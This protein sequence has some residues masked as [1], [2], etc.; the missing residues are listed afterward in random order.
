[1]TPAAARGQQRFNKGSTRANDLALLALRIARTARPN[2]PPL[3]PPL[4]LPMYRHSSCA[5]GAVRGTTWRYVSP[6]SPSLN[7]S[8][9]SSPPLPFPPH[10]QTLYLC[11]SGSEAN[12]LALRIA[13]TARPG[14]THVAVMAGAYHGHLQ[15]LIEMSPYKFW[16]TGG[17]GRPVHVH[18]LP[19]PDAYR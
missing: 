18:V 9:L 4:C 8:F 16:G 15:A 7:L 2:F 6:V 1:M 12:D 5:T 19:C 14:A 11:N 17:Q 3:L 10:L 13:R